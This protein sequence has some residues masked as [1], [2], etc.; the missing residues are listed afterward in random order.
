MLCV[1]K[2]CFALLA[3]VAGAGFAADEAYVAEIQKWRQENDEFLRSEKSPLRLV[4]RFQVAE[5]VSTIGSDRAFAIVLPDRAPQQLGTLTR[6]GGVFSFEAAKGTS[7][8]INGRPF[9]GST[10]LKVAKAP[11]PS[12]RISSGDFFFS[13]RPVGE[14]FYLLLQDSQ[15]SLLREFKGSTWFPID[16]VY[17]VAA[18]VQRLS[19][20]RKSP[21]TLHWWLGR[22]LHEFRRCR[23]PA[24]GTNVP[25]EGVCD[26]RPAFCDVPRPDFREG[27][28][29][30]RSLH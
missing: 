14:D 20:T 13:I 2:R 22:G 15:S 5:G 28:L 7:V 25:I 1:T 17:R 23:V 18:A 24:Y 30:R 21:G 19:A 3:V 26:W 6:H 12:D 11:E 9:V 4:G 10:N 27:N 16:A 29:W 8:A